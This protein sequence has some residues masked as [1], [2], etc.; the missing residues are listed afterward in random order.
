MTHYVAGAT[1]LPGTMVPNN[2]TGECP[3]KH[4]TP[5][6]AQRCIDRLDRSIKRGYGPN[7]FADRHVMVV[8]EKGHR[9]WEP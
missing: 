4:R 8:D 5:E 9:R 6:A 2:V 3:H 7:A 1:W